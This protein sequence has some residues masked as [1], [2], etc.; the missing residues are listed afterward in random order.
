[1]WFSR[2]DSLQN[3]TATKNRK[4]SF[5][6]LQTT[7]QFITNKNQK[8]LPEVFFFKNTYFKEHLQTTASEEWKD[9]RSVVSYYSC[10]R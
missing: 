1:M 9:Q 10:G 2:Q 7:Y 6:L 3:F 8:H 5:K 4:V